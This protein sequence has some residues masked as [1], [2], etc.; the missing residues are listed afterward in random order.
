MRIPTLTNRDEDMQKVSPTTDDLLIAK[1]QLKHHRAQ[2]LEALNKL[3]RSGTP[4]EPLLDGRYRGELIALD[5]APGLTQFFQW[6]TNAWMPWLGK[7][8]DASR[9][10]GDNIF[11]QDSYLLARLFNPF[12]RGFFADQPGTYR[13]FAFR[14]YMAS[15]LMDKDRT[16]LKIDYDQKDNPALTVRRVLDELVQIGDN[17]YLGK[18]HLL[19]WSG[20]WQTVAYF[21]LT[22]DAISAPN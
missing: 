10:R 14:T 5:L 20:S 22:R 7:T 2:G 9:Q 3:F 21:T 6:L 4:P 18:A 15:G 1:A 17:A 16:V 12:Y 19:W 11:T 8:F 13:G